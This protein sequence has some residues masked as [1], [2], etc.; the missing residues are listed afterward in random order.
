MAAIDHFRDFFRRDRS[1]RIHCE[2]GP[3]SPEQQAA[4]LAAAGKID[5]LAIK[6]VRVVVVD[7]HRVAANFLSA[8]A[9]NRRAGDRSG[10]LGRDL[11]RG[12]RE[13][14]LPAGLGHRWGPGHRRAHRLPG[15]GHRA[16]PDAFRVLPR[17][18]GTAGMLCDAYF[19]NGRP[20][21]LDPRYV[22]R[23]QLNRLAE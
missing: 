8:H 9:A 10:L 14:R 6:T 23:T 5:R 2:H 3:S 15:R 11:Q 22:L 21:P 13:P 19:S 4:A 17:A 16:R 20:V 12:L 7:Q 18:E 1:A